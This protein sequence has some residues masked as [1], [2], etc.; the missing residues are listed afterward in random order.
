V[1]AEDESNVK[2]AFCSGGSRTSTSAGRCTPPKYCSRAQSFGDLV[3]R[4]KYLHLLAQ[5]DRALV[6]RVEELRQRV[7][8][9][10]QQLVKLQTD[11]EHNR[12][13]RRARRSDCVAAGAGAADAAQGS[14]RCE[15]TRRRLEQLAATERRLNQFFA[16][17]E[18]ERRRAAARANAPAR[19]RARS[20]RQTSGSSRGRWTGRSSTVRAGGESEQHDHALERDRDRRGSGHAR[21]RGVGGTVVLSEVMGTYGNTIIVEHGGGDYSVYGALSRM[22]VRKG[23]RITKGQVI[24]AVGANDPELPPHL[25]FEIRRGGP[26]VDPLEW[27]RSQ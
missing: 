16:N 2:K 17:L 13:R 22:D 6:R 11:I 7:A 12:R 23:A 5:R 26:A 3:T 20:P 25:H 19:R 14:G 24:G 27:L 21:S 18:A 1:Q 10:R 4:Y 15:R 9:N 8:R